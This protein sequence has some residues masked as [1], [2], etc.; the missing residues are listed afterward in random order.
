[1]VVSRDPLTPPIKRGRRGEDPS[2][3]GAMHTR[4]KLPRWF[5]SDQR[6]K[7]RTQQGLNWTFLNQACLFGEAISGEATRV[8][9]GKLEGL[10][11]LQKGQGRGQIT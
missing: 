5:R 2:P 10:C 3:H 1:M 4:P 11:Q 8:T 6:E 7:C 9:P